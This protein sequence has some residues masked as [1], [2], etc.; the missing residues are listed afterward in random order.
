MG[1]VSGR[2]VVS[3]CVVEFTA[4]NNLFLSSFVFADAPI[5]RKQRKM[6]NTMD[7]HV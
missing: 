7:D 3:S 4:M 1:T 5:L 2:L 6:V